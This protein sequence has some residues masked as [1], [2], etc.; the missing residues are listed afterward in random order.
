MPR[1]ERARLKSGARQSDRHKW[2]LVRLHHS[3]FELRFVVQFQ[4]AK[5][6]QTDRP[7]DALTLGHL[8]AVSWTASAA[9]CELQL[10]PPVVM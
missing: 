7:I 6:L 3:N 2:E 1:L 10:G 8:P 9:S 5:R 4:E